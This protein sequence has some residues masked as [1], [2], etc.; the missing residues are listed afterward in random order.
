LPQEI[1]EFANSGIS[2]GIASVNMSPR[3]EEEFLG[4][5]A[6]CSTY[7]SFSYLKYGPMRLFSQLAQDCELK[8]GKV[9]W[10]A[11][12]SGPE[13]AD[14]SRTHFGIFGPGVTQLF[15]DGHV[16]D[17]HPWE[18]NEVPVM[19]AAALRGPWSIV[20]CHLTRP[21]VTI[22]DRAKLGMAHFFDAAKGAYLIRDYDRSR[23][24]GGCILVQGTMSTAN[25]VDILGELER[26]QL[27]VKLVAAT[28]PQLFAVQPREYRERI[29]G[30]ADQWDSTFI[31][32][33]SRRLMYDWI[34]NPLA[35]EYAMTSDF[36]D[37]WRTGGALDEVL[38]EAHLD[39]EHLL[40]GIER[41]VRDR[42]QRL[43]R[44]KQGL[45]AA[46]G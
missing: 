5:Y 41:F 30:S 39:P 25:V 43:Q 9:I 42:A 7:G 3:P 44:L 21:P 6:A 11:G 35:A 45:A 19:L 27:N 18:Y 46:E 37:R 14:D 32:N 1:T 13:T 40:A 12:H 31:S 36:D 26:R 33:R 15:P 8:T 10:I 20:A 16:C 23:P 22:P 4:F 17:I 34:R 2:C 28:S 38:E 29:F 24:R